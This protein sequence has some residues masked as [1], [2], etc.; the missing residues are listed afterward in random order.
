MRSEEQARYLNDVL[1]VSSAGVV[2]DNDELPQR[3]DDLHFESEM[4]EFVRESHPSTINHWDKNWYTDPHDECKE[5]SRKLTPKKISWRG[6][7]KRPNHVCTLCAELS[8]PI[9]T[10]I[11]SSMG[12]RP[13]A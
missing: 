8:T 10:E 9:A 4:T 2:G 1:G 5:C 11:R 13:T 7:G 6:D 3:D 12:A